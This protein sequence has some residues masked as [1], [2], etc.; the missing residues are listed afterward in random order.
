M[1]LSYSNIIKRSIN[2][3]SLHSMDDLSVML[4][5][6]N[7]LL[8][9]LTKFPDKQYRY[10]SIPKKNGKKRDIYSP[11]RSLRIVQKWIL[12]NILY[13]VRVSSRAMA[14]VRRDEGTRGCKINAKYHGCSL[15][16]LHM[17]IVNFYGNINSWQVF[18]LF[19]SLGYNNSVAMVLTN[20]CTLH[21]CLPQGAI[22]SPTLSN[23]I[24]SS[25]DDNITELCDQ[26]GIRYSRYADDLI[27]SC[28]NKLELYAV[29]NEV[30]QILHNNRFA[31]NKQKTKYCSYKGRVRITGVTI[32][33]SGTSDFELKAPRD[34]KRNL[35]AELQRMILTG[36]YK[37]KN[38]VLGII[39]YINQI[40][41]GNTYKKDDYI[42]KI[43]AYIKRISKQIDI[44][45]E[46]IQKY[47]DH[48]FYNDQEVLNAVSHDEDPEY[49]ISVED[50]RSDYFLNH[51]ELINNY[52]REQQSKKDETM[53]SNEEP[54]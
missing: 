10:F 7:T 20:L 14:F 45:P 31:E 42:D 23:L 34:M 12:I 21:G 32:H 9:Y 5:L 27:F 46:L 19:Q 28:D 25:I 8:Y 17:D 53:T 44:Y 39:S 47:N 13:K 11:N 41:S 1:A 36:D 49:Y 30:V 54:F 50:S 37:R 29:H 2:L 6:S 24:F 26:K 48:P 52:C 22:T 38:N 15:F 43:K 4:R 51:P 40:E 16:C 35:R 18:R 33:K 3:P